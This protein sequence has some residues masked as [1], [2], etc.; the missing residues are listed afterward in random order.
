MEI[1][2]Y[3]LSWM[4]LNTWTALIICAIEGVSISEWDE[5]LSL[6]IISIISFSMLLIIKIV[7]NGIVFPIVK[8]Y[9][10]KPLDK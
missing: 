2:V 4:L 7:W 8:E 9:R 6:F 3:I 5:Y 1:A 10:K